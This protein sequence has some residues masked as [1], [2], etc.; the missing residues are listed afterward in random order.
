MPMAEWYTLMASM[1]TMNRSNYY[2]HHQGYI[3]LLIQLILHYQNLSQKISNKCPHIYIRVYTKA[4]TLTLHT[5]TFIFPAYL[6]TCRQKQLPPPRAST[7]YWRERRRKIINNYNTKYVH[8]HQLKE[9]I[10]IKKR[11]IIQKKNMVYSG[12]QQNQQNKMTLL[13]SM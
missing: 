4:Y 8:T 11:K 1:S 7:Q 5:H 10:E 13:F 12:E 6:K 2:H 9:Y 3:T